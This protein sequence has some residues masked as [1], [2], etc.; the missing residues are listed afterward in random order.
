M[1]V[2]VSGFYTPFPVSSRHADK[3]DKHLQDGKCEQ[4]L[5][6]GIMI[7]IMK[8]GELKGSSRSINVV[9]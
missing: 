3:V 9:G 1:L 2:Y 4:G 5:W 7:M 8:E 6:L